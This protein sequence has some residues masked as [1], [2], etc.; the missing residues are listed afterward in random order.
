MTLSEAMAVLQLSRTG[1]RNEIFKYRT[2]QIA[3]EKQR[4]GPTSPIKLF[5]AEVY[6]LAEEWGR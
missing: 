2:L 6:K 5:E 4:R 3:N 1:V